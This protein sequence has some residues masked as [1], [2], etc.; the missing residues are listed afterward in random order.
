MALLD[1]E[2]DQWLVAKA[3]ALKEQAIATADRRRRR[4]FLLIAAEYQKL[5]RQF[6]SGQRISRLPIDEES[7]T[8]ASQDKPPPASKFGHKIWALRY[9]R[10]SDRFTK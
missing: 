4:Q 7:T 6:K 3:H 9:L 8:A 1:S 5:A 2:D 10:K